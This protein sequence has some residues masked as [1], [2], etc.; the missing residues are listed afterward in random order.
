MVEQNCD[1]HEK[2]GDR[3]API[4]NWKGGYAAGYAKGVADVYQR[5]QQPQP[6]LCWDKLFYDQHK[7]KRWD[8][9]LAKE[10]GQLEKLNAHND[11][12]YLGWMEKLPS[13]DDSMGQRYMGNGNAKAWKGGF[14]FKIQKQRGYNPQKGY[15]PQGG[16]NMQGAAW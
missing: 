8:D 2:H 1:F 9:N 5:E 6:K 11:R 7:A 14:D 15:N 12:M 13:Y 3:L 4:D 10:V 16:Y